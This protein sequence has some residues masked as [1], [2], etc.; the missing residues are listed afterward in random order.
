MR[1]GVSING[2]KTEQKNS[3]NLESTVWIV[4]RRPF[5]QPIECRLKLHENN[6]S[7]KSDKKIYFEVPLST[8]QKA[9]FV[10]GGGTGMLQVGN[11]KYHLW[12]YDMIGAGTTAA[13]GTVASA[14]GEAIGGG[15][16]I[17]GGAAGIAGSVN[18]MHK[19]GGGEDLVKSW[20]RVL[21][22]SQKVIKEANVPIWVVVLTVVIIL[23]IA[24]LWFIKFG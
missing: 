8:L 20:E 19:M 9:S 15:A 18:Y 4:S 12:F 24:V 6:L 16:E 23:S 7:L 14:A 13:I 3:P 5:S 21:S 1:L 17:V 10:M 22:P 11:K 2:M